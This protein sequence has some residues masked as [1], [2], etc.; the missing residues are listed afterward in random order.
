LEILIAVGLL[1][2]AILVPFADSHVATGSRVTISKNPMTGS[3][4]YDFRFL[5]HHDVSVTNDA[6]PSSDVPEGGAGIVIFGPFDLKATKEVRFFKGPNSDKDV[7]VQKVQAMVTFT[8]PERA[9]EALRAIK[10][11]AVTSELCSILIGLAFFDMLR[12]LLSSAEKGDL[13][14]D[15]NVRTLRQFGFL[16]IVLDLAKF[17]VGAILMSR[18]NSLVEP[19]FS[20][21]NWMLVNTGA[22]KLT[23]VF[24]G[25]SFLLLAEVFREGLKF[26]KDSDLT[27]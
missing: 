18:M 4:T 26:R 25:I 6:S 12:R 14:T 22:G 9:V 5:K 20:G 11:P 8:G 7:D 21:G 17:A 23:G 2:T 1:V 27:I 19:F 13:F 10:W 24:S 15:T 16:I 3:F